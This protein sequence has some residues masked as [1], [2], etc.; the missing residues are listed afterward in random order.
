MGTNSCEEIMEEDNLLARFEELDINGDGFLTMEEMKA[1]FE[2]EGEKWDTEDEEIFQQVDENGDG[3][4][5]IKEWIEKF[6]DKR[7]EEAVKERTKHRREKI[8]SQISILRDDFEK[9]DKNGDGFLD[10]DE[11]ISFEDW[12]NESL[13]KIECMENKEDSD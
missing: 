9:F 6:K 11:K 4:I 10:E 2:A 8:K 5:S 3:K 12:A 13:A 7:E 1:V